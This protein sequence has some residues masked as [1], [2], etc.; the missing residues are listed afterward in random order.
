MYP[1]SDLIIRVA[2]RPVGDVDDLVTALLARRSGQRVQVRYWRDDRLLTTT[3][4][5]GER[6][7]SPAGGCQA[8]GAR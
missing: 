4:Q 5:L 7:L 8:L 3:V 2:G 1:H 6:P